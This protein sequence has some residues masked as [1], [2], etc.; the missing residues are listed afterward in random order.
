MTPCASLVGRSACVVS[1]G[2]CLPIHRLAGDGGGM[3]IARLSPA[4]AMAAGKPS[5][6]LCRV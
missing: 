3:K 4:S 5:E 2:A 6:A 1:G